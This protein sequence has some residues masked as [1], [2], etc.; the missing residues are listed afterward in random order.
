MAKISI[1]EEDKNAASSIEIRSDEIRNIL[2]QVPRWIVRYG[3]IFILVV[4][5]ILLV[6]AAWLKYPDVIYARIKLTT[7]TPPADLTANT[8]ARIQHFFITDKSTVHK[9]Q[10]LLIFESAADYGDIARLEKALGLAFSIDSIIVNDYSNNLVLGE[11]QEPYANFLKKLQEY[12]SFV[13]LDYYKRKIT[14]IRYELEKYN[15][16]IDKLSE[17]EEVLRKEYALIEK[18]YQRDSMLFLEHVL[19]TSELE[20][21]EAEGLKKLFEWKQTK[22]ELASSQI[23]ISN[24]QQEILELELKLEENNR[25][26]LQELREA[27]EK[28]KG[29]IALWERKYVIKTPFEGQVSF[30]K[31]WSENQRVQ[32]GDIVMTVIPL[33]KGHM[34]GKIELSAKGAGKI[35]EGHRVIIRFDNFP[36]MEFGTISGTISSISLVPNNEQYSAEVKLDSSRLITNYNILLEFQQNMPGSAVI[37]TEDR[38]LLNRIFAPF[39]SAMKIQKS[40]SKYR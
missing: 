38:S 16:Y 13:N 35:S 5:F 7:E 6:G 4:F 25:G 32:E 39:K 3:T 10:I 2:G 9:G 27:Y 22:T 36:F 1:K 26:Y 28:L 23:E 14:L 12:N 29:Q 17:Q 11:I 37:I 40:Y 31:F 24:L 34:L 33:E 21:S 19:S 18:Q 8:S 30:T 15:H 20:K